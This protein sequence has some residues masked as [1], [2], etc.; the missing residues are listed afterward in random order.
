MQ[1]MFKGN[2]SMQDTH[3]Q[4]M[5]SCKTLQFRKTCLL[6]LVGRHDLLKD[7]SSWLK[8]HFYC[9]YFLCFILLKTCLFPRH[10]FN[11]APRHDFYS[12]IVTFIS[13]KLSTNSVNLITNFLNFPNEEITKFVGKLWWTFRIRNRIVIFVK[14]FFYNTVH[15][16]NI[17]VLKSIFVKNNFGLSDVS[18]TACLAARNSSRCCE[19][20]L[21][22]HCL[23]HRRL[24]L[25]ALSTGSL[26]QPG[27]CFTALSLVVRGA[28]PSRT[29]LQELLRSFKRVLTSV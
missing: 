25:R 27:R 13:L 22:R 5:S 17:T 12:D 14:K 20:P 10:V 16:L 4:I 11:M 26:Y 1:D 28:C 29:T 3:T 19:E 18:L 15:I 6:S 2:V 8:M 7:M 24:S 23:S 9:F 21:L